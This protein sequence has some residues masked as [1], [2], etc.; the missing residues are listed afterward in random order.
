M[1]SSGRRHLRALLAVVAASLYVCDLAAQSAKTARERYEAAQQ[2]DEK[3]R[4]LLT[5][6]TNAPPPADLT[7]QVRQVTA[8]FESIV[9]RFPTSGYAD[10]ALWQAASLADAAYQRV[11]QPDDRD[12]ALKLYRWLMQEYPSSPFIKQ[13]NARVSA[14]GNAPMPSI[15]PAS[16]PADAAPVPSSPGKATLSSIQ[17]VNLPGSVRI[18]LEL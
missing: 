7:T 18:T 17:R 13:A 15:S 2:R 11:N 14:L 9:R 10:N 6:F 3:V 4:V 1:R 12:R 8:S 5:N 16:V